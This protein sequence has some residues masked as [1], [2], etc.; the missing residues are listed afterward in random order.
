[1]HGALS[2]MHGAL[3]ACHVPSL[4]FSFLQKRLL[5]GPMRLFLFLDLSP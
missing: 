5:H 2:A 4:V 1:M 3:M